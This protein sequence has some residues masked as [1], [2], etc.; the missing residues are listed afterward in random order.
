MLSRRIWSVAVFL[1]LP[2]FACSLR[3]QSSLTVRGEVVSSAGQAVVGA[4]VQALESDVGGLTNRRGR[5]AL[6]GLSGARLVLRVAARGYEETTQLVE[7]DR[8]Q[9]HAVRIVLTLSI[10]VPNIVK[11][12]LKF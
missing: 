7:M 3:A 4:T 11:V 5:F 8:N 9:T 10:I 1:C 6:A 12:M 2:L